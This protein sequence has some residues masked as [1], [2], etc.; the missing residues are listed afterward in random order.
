MSRRGR[1][2]DGPPRQ[3][4]FD[5]LLQLK[6]SHHR[7]V[8]ALRRKLRSDGNFFA[9][10]HDPLRWVRGGAGREMRIALKVGACSIVDK[11]CV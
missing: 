4:D 8:S 3:I 6:N 9:F 1:V 7:S 2:W 5:R 10:R 11:T